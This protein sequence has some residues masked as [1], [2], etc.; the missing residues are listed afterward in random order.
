MPSTGQQKSTELDVAKL[1][2]NFK[3]PWQKIETANYTTMVMNNGHQDAEPSPRIRAVH[4][5]LN[6][7]PTMLFRNFSKYY[8]LCLSLLDFYPIIQVKI[9]HL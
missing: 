3:V 5:M 4:I 2:A 9:Q 7:S 6:Y 1:H 8:L